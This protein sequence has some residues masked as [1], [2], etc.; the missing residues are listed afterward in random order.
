MSGD[1]TFITS[2]NRAETGIVSDVKQIR[3]G[4]GAVTPIP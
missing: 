3:L 1:V 2:V 4:T